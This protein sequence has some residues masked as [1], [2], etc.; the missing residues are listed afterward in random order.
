LTI[1][2]GEATRID[3]IDTAVFNLQIDF[4]AKQQRN[5]GTRRYAGPAEPSPFEQARDELF[6]HIMRCGVVG[7]DP[8]HMDEW[9]ADTMKYMSDRFPEL[10]EQ[11]MSELRTLGQRFAQPPK[12]RTETDAASAA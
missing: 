6:Q 10:G 5:T 11:Q 4:M 3:Y 9:F 1:R 7:A 2:V 12:T 8:E